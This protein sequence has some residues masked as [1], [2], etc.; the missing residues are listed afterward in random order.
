MFF[1]LASHLKN[2]LSIWSNRE[3]LRRLHEE[4]QYSW[5]ELCRECNFSLDR[6]V[7]INIRFL[8]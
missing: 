4:F 6:Q 8:D 2:I 7:K 5:D 1:E 3:D